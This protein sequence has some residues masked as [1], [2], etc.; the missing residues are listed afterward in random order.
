MKL[1]IDVSGTEYN[2]CGIDKILVCASNYPTISWYQFSSDYG[3]I[4]S[5]SYH[6]YSNRSKTIQIQ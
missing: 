3:S 6:R 4:V 1:E 5:R 2:R